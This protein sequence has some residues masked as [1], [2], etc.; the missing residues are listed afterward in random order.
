MMPSIMSGSLIRDTPPWAR[1]SAGT[2]SSAMTATA[3]ASSA[4][5]ACSAVTTS[6]ITPP[7]SISAMPRL[8]RA[9]PVPW[10]LLC[11]LMPHSVGR[12]GAANP[13]EQPRQDDRAGGSSSSKVDRL[14]QHRV[15]PEPEQP[16]RALGPHP[17]HLAGGVV[18]EP[19]GQLHPQPARGDPLEHVVDEVVVAAAQLGDDLAGEGGPQRLAEVALDLLAAAEVLALEQVVGDRVLGGALDRLGGGVGDDAGRWPGRAPRC[20][21]ARGRPRPGAPARRRGPTSR[22][23]PCCAGGPGA[24]RSRRGTR[25]PR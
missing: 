24:R 12:R 9:V 18:V 17:A 16:H 20:W 10:A 8:T 21:R 2:R 22:P 7:L 23:R 13:V 14:G 3:P 4:I 6:M 19:A 5:W 11:S 15:A 25:R 1:M